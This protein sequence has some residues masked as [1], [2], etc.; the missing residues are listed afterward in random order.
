MEVPQRAKFFDALYDILNATDAE[1]FSDLGAGWLRNAR[2]I[3]RHY[4]CVDEETRRVI[5][6]V[7]FL[8][9][10][11]ST[12]SL[13][14]MLPLPGRSRTGQRSLEGGKPKQLPPGR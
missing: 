7:L 5:G 4:S 6:K 9:L 8:L 13:G 11:A 12:Q 2:A 10:K 14:E 1:T 3:L